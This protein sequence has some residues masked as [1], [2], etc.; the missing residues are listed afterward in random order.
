MSS[1]VAIGLLSGCALVASDNRRR[2]RRVG[3]L[4]YGPDLAPDKP[5]LA[6]FR[7]GIG[8]L[9]YVEGQ[10][11]TLEWRYGEQSTERLA[12][13]ADELVRLS[14]D[15]LFTP[16]VL[17]IRA[18]QQASAK[19]PI[20]A[21]CNDPVAM[22][23]VASLARPAGNVTGLATLLGGTGAKRVELFKQA[24][25]DLARVAVLSDSIVPDR[26]TDLPD[27]LTAA[28][29]LG[30]ELEL[31][32]VRGAGGL[33]GAFEAV[34]DWH[35][36]GIIT[37]LDVNTGAHQPELVAFALDHRLPT[38]CEGSGFVTLRGGLMSYGPDPFGIFEHAA[39]YVDRILKG[40]RPGEL[41]VEQPTR[42]ELA[43]NLATARAIGRT[44]PRSILAEADKVVQ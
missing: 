33:E 6:A 2:V 13:L 5:H 34:L 11:L 21:I 9:G 39:S 27:M 44:I 10:D 32:D 43:L 30:M 36:N 22:G 20:V 37:L 16:G 7:K 28:H 8:D 4:W 15:V 40:A 26:N 42:V 14:V 19:I 38:I 29:T 35:A 23:F 1:V 25:P 3:V 24:I 17:A 41:P 18:A 12:E 31:F